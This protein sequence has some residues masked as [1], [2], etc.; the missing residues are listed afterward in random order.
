MVE[1]DVETCRRL[2]RIIE[3][4]PQ[5]E[6][7]GYA[8]DF[9]TGLELLTQQT[10]GVLLTDLG[11]PDGNGIDLILAIRQ[12][13]LATEAMVITVF[14]DERHVFQAIEA[15]ATGYLLKDSDATSIGDAITQLLEGGSPISPAIARHVLRRVNQH[16]VESNSPPQA[17][18]LTSRELEVMTLLGKG[19]TYEEVAQ[20]LS[21]SIGT[22]T[23]HIK[24]IYRKL[25]VRSRGEAVFEAMQLGLLNLDPP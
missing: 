23:T 11:L 6:L 10:P 14:G 22:V 1:D 9:A 24:H 16:A 20:A 18:L 13:K 12:L 25:A 8:F 4:H 21:M 2:C 3:Q 7:S 15:G 17:S 19:L 5:F